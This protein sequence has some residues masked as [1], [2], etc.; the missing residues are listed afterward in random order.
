MK[1]EFL[2]QCNVCAGAALDVIDE[3]CNIMRCKICGYIFDNPRP[4]PE[5]LIKFYSRPAQYDSW[6]REIPER[7]RLWR[8]R[9]KKLQSTRKPGSVLDVGTGI[10]Q[11]LAV[12]RTSYRDVYGTEVSSTAVQI[13]KQKYNLN[14]FHGTI[15]S[16]KEQNRVFDNI[17]LFHVLEHV[18]DPK[19]TLGTCHSLLSDNGVLVIAVPNEV[20]SFRA[21]MK[22]TL[23]KLGLK[24]RAGVGKFGL[25]GIKLGA[26]TDEVHLSHFTPRVLHHLLRIT[27]FSIVKSTL[28]PYYVRTGVSRMKAELYYGCCVA[29][30]KLFRLNIFDAMLVIA[31]KVST[32]RHLVRV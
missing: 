22:R 19:S 32:D 6:L 7:D 4:A 11:F 2:E 3:E 13:A 18:P 12:A 27:G 15:E 20:A 24:K 30:H 10:G 5:E 28:D 1:T 9:L 26:H 17:S 14:L 16:L 29:F 31:R 23:L 25:S 8:R 21:L